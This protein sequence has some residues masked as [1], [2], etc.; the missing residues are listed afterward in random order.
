MATETNSKSNSA[1]ASSPVAPG[2][3]LEKPI[4]DPNA[5]S[6]I[7]VDHIIKKYGDFTAVE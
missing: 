4:Y 2:S 5:P 1:S 7:E 3:M 6:A